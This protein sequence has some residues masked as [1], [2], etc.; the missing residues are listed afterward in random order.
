MNCHGSK[1]VKGQFL[2]SKKLGFLGMHNAA[3]RPRALLLTKAQ[4]GKGSSNLKC[5]GRQIKS[6]KS[7]N[8]FVRVGS[9]KRKN[10]SCKSRDMRSSD[11]SVTQMRSRNN[12]GITRFTMILKIKVDTVSVTDIFAKNSRFSSLFA[13]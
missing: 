5:R 6:T 10:R 8:F 12:P 11:I 9:I 4:F 7:F 2:R 13:F 3:P 1:H